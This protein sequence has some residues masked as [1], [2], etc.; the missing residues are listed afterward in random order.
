MK[1]V[2]FII[3]NENFWDANLI[4]SQN[5]LPLEL[6][7]AKD[8]RIQIRVHCFVPLFT[9]ILK[10]NS[11]R[12][13]AQAR[14]A[15]GIL[16]NFIPSIVP[17][18]RLS[19]RYFIIPLHLIILLPY[20]GIKLLLS[21]GQVYHARSYLPGLALSF[22]RH[23]RSKFIFDPRSDFINENIGLSWSSRSLTQFLWTRFERRILR[24]AHNTI[25]I[26]KAMRDDI[27]SRNNLD[28]NFPNIHILYNPVQFDI[29]KQ[30]FFKS[31]DKINFL[32]T[33]S[34]NNWNNLETYLDFYASIVS[35]FQDSVL[36]IYTN[37]PAEKLRGID[38]I[39]RD[40]KLK[41]KV[42]ISKIDPSEI[43]EKY[44]GFSFGLQLMTK[45]D[46]RVG[47]KYVEYLSAGVIPITNRNV[48]GAAEIS[49]GLQYGIVL[50]DL[51]FS[52]PEPTSRK[53]ISAFSNLSKIKNEALYK[54]LYNMFDVKTLANKLIYIYLGE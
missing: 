5:I 51:D 40:S 36:Q 39:N 30:T 21:P 38:R 2:N 15:N 20:L 8:E 48:R 17:M 43:P 49:Q 13:F 26:S 35:Y 24:K 28:L 10:N 46:S 37:T 42:F 12:Q 11:I 22:F 4:Y 19:L 32:Y 54:K 52:N 27:C 16:I 33:G 31:R 6:I 14:K 25:F 34:L 44:Q 1:K 53:I 50:D 3:Y 45:P 29:L 18:A 7:T 47:V 23:R 9:L 41:N